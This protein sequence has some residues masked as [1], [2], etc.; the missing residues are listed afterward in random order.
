[1]PRQATGT[2]YESHGRWYARVTVGTGKRQSFALP[3]CES[4]TTADGRLA[5]LAAMA[6]TLR[7]GKVAPD[8]AVRLLERA[9][10]AAEGKALAA[11]AKTAEALARGE[12]RAKPAAAVTFRDL[13]ER[14]LSGELAREYPDHVQTVKGADNI[15]GTLEN[16]VYS[17]GVG[18]IPIASFT[19]DHA[20]DVMRAIPAAR[21]A[22]TRRGIAKVMHRV[23]ALATFP[24]RLI[25][26]NPL[27]RGFLPRVGEGKVKAWL[28]PDE[29]AKL[30]G[31]VA[32]PLCWR[33]FYGALNREGPRAS[34]AIRFD[35]SDADLERGAI[36]LDENKTDDP[37]AWAL[38]G[39][40][41]RAFRAWVAMRER[42]AKR[43]LRPDEPL[44][45]G[46][47][48]LRIH[49][50]WLA[51]Q[52]RGHLQLAGVD[53]AELFETTATR[54][55]IRLHDTRATFITIALANG[56]SETWVADR[57][58][59]KSSNQINGYR[60]AART[61]A[62]LGLGELVP[63]DVAIPELTAP[64]SPGGGKGSGNG[65]A[66]GGASPASSTNKRKSKNESRVDAIAAENSCR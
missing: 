11:I 54:R 24:L 47:D 66:P 27:P 35:L 12:V 8:L 48:G 62:E 36:K 4:E 15:R 42:D 29:D 40:V 7:G 28:Y 5:V 65:S 49:A 57:T 52:Y 3:T 13:A 46:K 53:R 38:D 45:T 26:S 1:M 50:R 64:A 51:E 56:R 43:P 63:L 10:A 9:G 14:W 44:F 34:E 21:E 23:L 60:R 58:G 41:V 25:T 22:G 16:H 33:M 30:L 59:H 17:R 31:C 20:E 18:D 61:A 2:T 19:L 32:V 55:Q 6:K 37:R 39:G